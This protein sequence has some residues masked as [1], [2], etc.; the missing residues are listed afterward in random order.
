MSNYFLLDQNQ[1]KENNILTNTGIYNKKP[2][3]INSSVESTSNSTTT[4]TSTNNN[5]ETDNYQKMINQ[6]GE[7]TSVLVDIVNA[8]EKENNLLK[9]EISLNKKY[10]NIIYLLTV[11]IILILAVLSACLMKN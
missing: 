9:K 10:K 2:V 11:L 1:Y 8:I 3:N 4:N 7:Q 6:L 5:S